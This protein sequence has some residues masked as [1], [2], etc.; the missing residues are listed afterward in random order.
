MIGLDFDLE[1]LG[2]GAYGQAH[3]SYFEARFAYIF[4]GVFHLGSHPTAEQHDRDV[5]IGQVLLGQGDFDNRSASLQLRCVAMENQVS[6]VGDQGGRFG[7]RTLDENLGC[8]TRCVFQFVGNQFNGVALLTRPAHKPGSVGVEARLGENLVLF[9]V[10]GRKADDVVSGAF[11]F[12][13]EG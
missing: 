8:F 4:L 9:A 13:L 10:G 6:L 5:E 1:T 11:R 3:V 2:V 7:E 12:D